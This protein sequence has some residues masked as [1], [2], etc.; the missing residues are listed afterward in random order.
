MVNPETQNI[1]QILQKLLGKSSGNKKTER[2][3]FMFLRQPFLG[4]V[5]EKFSAVIN[6]VSIWCFIFSE[7]I[8]KENRPMPHTYECTIWNKHTFFPA[9]LLPIPLHLETATI[10]THLFMSLMMRMNKISTWTTV[11]QQ[12]KPCLHNDKIQD[13]EVKA[14]S[15]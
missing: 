9:S 10:R 2:L 14:N 3:S 8:K 7:C 15:A 5:K 6:K 12:W 1:Q 13:M 4:K 11:K